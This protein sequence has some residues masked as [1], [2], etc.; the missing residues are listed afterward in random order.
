MQRTYTFTTLE[1][2]E[3][4]LPA[5]DPATVYLGGE[6]VTYEGLIYEARHWTQKMIFRVNL[7]LMVHGDL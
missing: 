2:S 5:W 4:T 3:S 7:V 6:R 1:E